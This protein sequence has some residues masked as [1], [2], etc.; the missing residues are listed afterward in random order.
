MRSRRSRASRRPQRTKD[1]RQPNNYRQPCLRRTLTTPPPCP[2]RG[3]TA[4]NWGAAAAPVWARLE[5]TGAEPQE[6]TR[7]FLVAFF[8][9]FEKNVALRTTYA[10]SMRGGFPSFRSGL[11]TSGGLWTPG[12]SS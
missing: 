6:R 5:D 4:E 10:M 7:R 8:V 1:H 12:L 2:W 3:T 9:A 11:R